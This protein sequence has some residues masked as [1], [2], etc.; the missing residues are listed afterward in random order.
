MINCPFA[1]NPNST[2]LR[3]VGQVGSCWRLFIFVS[4][5]AAVQNVFPTFVP[6]YDIFDGEDGNC[7]SRQDEDD[8]WQSHL[9]FAFSAISTS[10]R[11]ASERSN[12]RSAA[13]LSMPAINASG[14]RAATSLSTPVAGRPTFRLTDIDFAIIFA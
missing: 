14:M 5:I 9:V 7:Q 4:D 8:I 10:L 11:M 1:I 2:S 6:P 13:H 12:E 3:W